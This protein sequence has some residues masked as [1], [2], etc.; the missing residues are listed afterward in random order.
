METPT[1]VNPLG[2]K[3]AGESGTIGSIPAV[4]NAVVDA[5]APLGVTHL[6]GP[7]TPARV[8]EAIQAAA[9]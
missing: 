7:C 6:D 4:I 1:W 9:D 5:L 3:G 8:W 2:A